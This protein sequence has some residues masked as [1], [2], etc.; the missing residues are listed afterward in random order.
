MQALQYRRPDK[1]RLREFPDPEPA[2]DEI[3]LE[4][5]ACG[6]CGT[7]L[8]ILAG[9]APSASPV[10]LGHEFSG[11]VI[12]TGKQVSGIKP[13]TMIAVDPNNYCG[14]CEYCHRGAVHLCRNIR[15][16]GI[17]RNGGWAEL[18]VVPAVQVHP[19]PEHLDPR[20][21]ALAEPLSCIIHGW[22]RIAPVSCN[23]GVLVMGAGIIGLLWALFLRGNGLT[24]LHL[25]EPQPKRREIAHRLGF[26]CFS[27]GALYDSFDIIIDCSGS[28]S[29][30]EQAFD[31]LKPGGK[32]LLFGI[33][34]PDARISLAPFKIFQQEWTILGSVINPFTFSR[35]LALL[36]ALGID[37][38][39][40]GIV[41][42]PLA[43]YEQALQA[44]RTGA[45][46][47]VMF[48]LRHKNQ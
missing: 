33:A 20:L 48:D 38:A 19:V 22:D 15:P 31:H 11:M 45:A 7:D 46:T 12:R 3:L 47:K 10:I 39:E 25:T 28:P 17:A 2:D 44:A 30:I 5:A 29:A 34:P 23:R 9:E 41:T 32:S 21:A 26:S 18:C 1:L 16:I 24:D 8:H 40:L 14:T 35:A 42:F 27:P 4:V 36:P 43:G 13:G 6:I 37:P